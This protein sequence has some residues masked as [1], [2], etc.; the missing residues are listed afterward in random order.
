MLDA[1]SQSSG[2]IDTTIELRGNYWLHVNATYMPPLIGYF[3]LP[4]KHP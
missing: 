1:V 2:Q 4:L 3:F